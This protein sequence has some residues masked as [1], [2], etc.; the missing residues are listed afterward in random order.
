MIALSAEVP[1]AEY[2]T[3]TEEASAPEILLSK[4]S[5]G[6]LQALKSLYNDMAP[7]L[8]ATLVRMVKKRDVAEDLLQDT[9]VHIWK[10]AH[11]FDSS[12]GSA[13]AWLVSLT[14]RKAIDL[15]R[16]SN[17]DMLCRGNQAD[18]LEYE[19]AAPNHVVDSETRIALA[20]AIDMLKPEIRRAMTLCYFYGL[21]HEELAG[22]LR[23]PLGTA[24]SWIKRGLAQVKLCMIP[25]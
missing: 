24:K 18:S 11:L 22:E 4:I 15:I 3:V 21:T 9:F 10:K 14:R 17:R 1:L 13:R 23:V 5:E 19:G 8:F 7:L 6:D 16:A 25:T 2:I 12:R 20:R